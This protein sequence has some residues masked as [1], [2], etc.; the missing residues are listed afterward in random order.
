MLLKQSSKKT[1]L[2]TYYRKMVKQVPVYHAIENLA[3]LGMNSYVLVLAI[4]WSWQG[5]LII[6]PDVF[7]DAESLALAWQNKFLQKWQELKKQ[8]SLVQL[9]GKSQK[10][11]NKFERDSEQAFFNVLSRILRYDQYYLLHLDVR[12]LVLRNIHAYLHYLQIPVSERH[13]QHLE[14][15]IGFLFSRGG[16]IPQAKQA[17][18]AL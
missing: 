16:K 6:D 18:L 3:Q 14:A 2:Y 5:K 13:Y 10:K 7:A 9:N 11:I 15:L 8:I 17:S 12:E 4:W 1:D